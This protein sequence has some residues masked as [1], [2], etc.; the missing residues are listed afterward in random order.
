MTPAELE[1]LERAL[2][3]LR[4]GSSEPL[5]LRLGNAPEVV[6]HPVDAR[7]IRQAALR[8]LRALLRE[9]ERRRA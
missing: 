8:V 6:L 5:T 7:P 2:V 1:A 9:Q 4:W 3:A